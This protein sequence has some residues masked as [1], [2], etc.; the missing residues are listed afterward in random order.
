MKCDVDGDGDND[1][2]DDVDASKIQAAVTM[3]S[4]CD[5]PSRGKVYVFS[6]GL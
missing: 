1:K 5:L 6:G 3:N 4:L 2:D